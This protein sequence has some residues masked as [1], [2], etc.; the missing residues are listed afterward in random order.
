MDKEIGDQLVEE[1]LVCFSSELH[2]VLK[3]RPM[4]SSTSTQDEIR[5]VH[6]TLTLMGNQKQRSSRHQNGK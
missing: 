4:I 3:I 6:R 1:I 5:T 2:E